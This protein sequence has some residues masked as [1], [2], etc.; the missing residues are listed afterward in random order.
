MRSSRTNDAT[1]GPPNRTPSALESGRISDF[2]YWI[3]YSFM[4]IGPLEC[5]SRPF[6]HC[7]FAS[8]PDIFL[9]KSLWTSIPE[10]PEG[11]WETLRFDGRLPESLVLQRPSCV[12]TRSRGATPAIRAMLVSDV[13]SKGYHP[14]AFSVRFCPRRRGDKIQSSPG[15]PPRTHLLLLAIFLRQ[16]GCKRCPAI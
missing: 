1:K 3:Q 12:I 8:H 7:N 9:N 2:W 11:A 5:I 14:I 13:S 16:L 10:V 6:H 4:D 15:S